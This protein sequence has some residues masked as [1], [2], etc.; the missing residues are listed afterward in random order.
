MNSIDRIRR[1]FFQRHSHIDLT[2]EQV[3]EMLYYDNHEW[4][5][6]PTEFVAGDLVWFLGK[7][8]V[9]CRGIIT[10]LRKVDSGHPYYVIRNSDDPTKGRS[11]RVGDPVFGNRED[12]LMWHIGENWRQLGRLWKNVENATQNADQLFQYANRRAKEYRAAINFLENQLV[13]RSPA[14]LIW[15]AQEH[16]VPGV[17]SLQCKVFGDTCSHSGWCDECPRV[18]E[19]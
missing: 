16:Q 4:P 17:K 1:F 6:P 19:D 2:Q 14:E 10:K 15:D 9:P 18:T 5:E 8:K 13:L 11:F 7:G 3:D 12:L